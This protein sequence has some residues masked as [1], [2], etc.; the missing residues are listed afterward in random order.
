MRLINRLQEYVLRARGGAVELELGAYR[1]LLA[2]IDEYDFANEDDLE[3]QQRSA[4]LAARAR[5]GAGLDR[6]LPEAFALAREV[7][8]RVLAMRP[9][10]VQMIAGIAMHQGKL[11]EMPT[12]EGKTLAA[13][14]PVYLNALTGQGVHLLTF[15]DYLARRDA[16]WMGPVYE[17]LGLSVGCVQQETD[18]AGRQEA[19]GCDITYLTAKQAGFDYLRDHLC[20]DPS[21]LVHR[22]FHYAIVDEADSILID[23]ARVPLVIAGSTDETQADPTRA[24]RLVD[25]LEP[26]RHFKKD[27]E[28][29]NVQFTEAGFDRLEV[30]LACGDLHDADNLPLLTELSMA[31]H[32]RAL[33]TRDVDYVVRDEAVELVDEFTGRVVPDRRWPDGLQAAVE[34]KE[35]VLLK[36]QGVIRGS[37]TL[38]HYLRLYPKAAGMTATARTAADEFLEFYEMNVVVI[39]PNRDCIRRDEDDVVFT[40]REAK[41]RA[42][43]AE[44]V[45]LQRTGRPVLVGTASVAESE[46]LAAGLAEAGVGCEILNAKNDEGEARI[47]ARAATVGAVTISTNMAGRGTDIRLGGDPPQDRERIVDLGGL[48]VVG[49]NRHESRRID[50]QLRGRAG[51]Q[52]DPGSSR[53]YVSLEDDLVKRFGIKDLI[54]SQYRELRQDGPIDDPAVTRVISRAQRTIEEQTFEIRRTLWRYTSFIEEQRQA[55]HGRRQSILKDEQPLDLIETR[56]R[57]RYDELLAAGV[58]R[59]VLQQVEKVITLFLF[60]ICWA[61]YLT[62]VADIREHIHLVVM[63]NQSPLDEFHKRVGREYAE[64]LVRID[65]GIIKT[66]CSV[67]I[68]PAGIDLDK[69]GLRGP[70]STWTYL[71]NDN[72]FGDVLQRMFRGLKRMVVEDREEE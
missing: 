25:E 69:A 49:T 35:G 29:R 11:A 15:N 47:V 56:A 23:E 32:A 51:R 61:D 22:E 58:P 4:D 68:T 46:E 10:D 71:I 63:A 41:H 30:E 59:D 53:F 60:D 12:G 70:S 18:I 1:R 39:P 55:V 57:E 7:S 40:H 38:Q 8:R 28:S 6:L 42:I 17:F 5:G 44:I 20:T 14:A 43:V 24:A 9:F 34:S 65:Q 66:F 3:L 13:V 52:G 45:E 26:A 19:Y 27:Q 50:G 54:P 62:R 36:P 37:I 64:L 31:L 48:Y 16:Q 2:K 21:N 33:L 72:P 67:E